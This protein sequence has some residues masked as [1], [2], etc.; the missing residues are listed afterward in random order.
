VFVVVA[1][2]GDG[3]TYYMNAALHVCVCVCVRAKDSM[4]MMNSHVMGEKLLPGML[5]LFKL[6]PFINYQIRRGG[7]NALIIWSLTLH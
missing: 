1:Y 2:E 6:F 7:N 3:E 5:P 4:K